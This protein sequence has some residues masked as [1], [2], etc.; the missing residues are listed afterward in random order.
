[1]TCSY[2]DLLNVF[3]WLEPEPTNYEPNI[4]LKRDMTRRCAQLR[5]SALIFSESIIFTFGQKLLL[6]HQPTC[7][8][9]TVCLTSRSI[10]CRAL[11]NISHFTKVVLSENTHGSCL[12]NIIRKL[13]DAQQF[14]IQAQNNKYLQKKMSFNDEETIV[15]VNVPLGDSIAAHLCCRRFLC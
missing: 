7:Y 10:P 6:N 12:F 11:R 2:S 3:L 13:L 15:F 9:C 1:M 14:L 4:H 8:S 5:V